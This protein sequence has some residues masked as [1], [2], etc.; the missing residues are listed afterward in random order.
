MRPLYLKCDRCFHIIGEHLFCRN[1]GVVRAWSAE[2][3]RWKPK[4]P[5]PYD[6]S[7]WDDLQGPAW[8]WLDDAVYMG[9]MT[10]VKSGRQLFEAIP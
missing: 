6:D 8:A 10:H 9:R 5:E 1:H 4:P 7:V 2:V 3:R